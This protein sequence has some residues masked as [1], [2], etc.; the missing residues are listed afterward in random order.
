LCAAKPRL[1]VVV[2]VDQLRADSFARAG[3]SA[4]FK[5]LNDEGAVFTSARHDHVPT[6]TGPGHAAIM[7]GARPG[8]NGIIG[9]E[10]YDRSLSTTVY[11]V[12]DSLHGLGPEHLLS[13]TLGD[14]LKAAS[15]ESLVVSVS[16]KDRAAIL[17]G[18]KKPDAAVWYDRKAGVFTTSSYYARPKWLDQ[19]NARAR[20]N[21][22]PLAGVTDFGN[23]VYT[24]S[25]D[26]AVLLLAEEAL[27]RFQL[28]SHDAPDV[29]AVSF[30]ATDYIGHK[31]GFEGKEMSGHLKKLD[32]MLGELLAAAEK[33]AGKGRVDVALTADHG[34]TPR[35]EDPRGRKQKIKRVDW[36]ALGDE[37][38]RVMQD[39]YPSPRPWVLN[40]YPNIYLSTQ[41]AAGLGVDWL[42][43]V[44]Q[45]AG[46]MD[47]A[48]DVARAYVPEQI[49]R[50]D[51]YAEAYRRSVLPGRSGDVVIRVKEGVMVTD[52]P[53][54]A[55]HGAPYEDDSR[56][57]L[58]FWGADFKPGVHGEPTPVVDLA[59]TCAAALGVPLSSAEGSAHS[60]ILR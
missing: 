9:N 18:G 44:K 39:H 33:A 17:M 2:S 51:P 48:P 30:S 46:F 52:R 5:R 8:R 54:G 26:A 6:E 25:A 45:A 43:V 31:Y 34:V 23:F 42:T 53:A 59:P 36:D 27:D 38:E 60:D 21:G 35:P 41:N 7:T 47:Q 32:G 24:S 20:E 3:Y 29:L 4:G 22:A 28:G 50:S 12:E 57:P 15:P 55:D 14:A 1:L 11:V 40:E 16:V 49:D 10:W 19:F 58:V 37:L 56:V 13:Y